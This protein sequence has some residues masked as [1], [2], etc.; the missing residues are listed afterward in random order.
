M[1]HYSRNELNKLSKELLIEELRHSNN[2]LI[3]FDKTNFSLFLKS[4]TLIGS[5]IAGLNIASISGSDITK[6]VLIFIAIML[7]VMSFGVIIVILAERYKKLII[8]VIKSKDADIKLMNQF[9]NEF[10]T[11]KENKTI[12]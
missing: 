12:D 10:N 7:V 2:K 9:V 4:L 6:Y 5:M 3:H 1:K 8:N 11:Y